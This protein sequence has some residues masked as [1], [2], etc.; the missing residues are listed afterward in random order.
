MRAKRDIA[1]LPEGEVQPTYASLKDMSFGEWVRS[2][3]RGCEMMRGAW[4]VGLVILVLLLVSMGSLLAMWWNL[5]KQREQE[6]QNRESKIEDNIH[7]TT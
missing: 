7:W 3:Q 1:T 5:R 4:I 2:S 6:R